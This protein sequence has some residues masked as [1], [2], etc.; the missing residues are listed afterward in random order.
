LRSTSRD[1]SHVLRN[2]SLRRF[3]SE[4]DT[5]TETG[6]SEGYD[7]GYVYERQIKEMMKKNR[8]EGKN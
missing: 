7:E 3:T 8:R 1:S 6:R 4:I 2:G 5:E